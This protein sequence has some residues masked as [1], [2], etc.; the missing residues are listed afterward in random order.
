MSNNDGLQYTTEWS[1]ADCDRCVTSGDTYCKGNSFFENPSVCVP[2][3]KI[4]TGFFK[5]CDDYSFGADQIDSSMSCSLAKVNSAQVFTFLGPILFF[6]F[7][8]LFCGIR[9]Q[10][11][12]ARSIA[13][14]FRVNQVHPGGVTP[15]PTYQVQGQ[16]QYVT[17]Q[18]NYQVQVQPQ[19]VTPQPAHTPTYQVQG[20]PQ[21]VT[22]QPNPTPTYQVQGQPQYVYASP[23]TL[24]ATPAHG[25]LNY[26][27][28]PLFGTQ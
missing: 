8:L 6:V 17:P 28:S 22:P 27:R 3:E 11:R 1:E 20:Q 13:Q 12:R 2:A 10:R 9:R 7:T 14:P 15:M 5:D 24:N 23:S 26:V 25:E 21:Y 4:K 16:P 18:P 19:Y